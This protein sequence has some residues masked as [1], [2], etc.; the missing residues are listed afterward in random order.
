MQKRIHVLSNTHWDREWYMPL[1]KYRVRLVRMMDRL[2]DLMEREEDYLFVTD[3]QYMMVEDYLEVRPESRERV[4]ALVRAGRLLVGPWYTQ[5]LETLVTG[6]AMVRNLLMGTRRSRALGG[7]MRFAYMVDEFGHASQT[8]QVLRGFGIGDML[9]W[10]GM[11]PALPPVFTWRAP[12]GTAVTMHRSVAG[13]GE[14]TALPASMEDFTQPYEGMELARSGLASRIRRIQEIKERSA[15]DGVQFWLN[16]IDH[17]W[18][19]E[20]LMERLAQIRAHW[21]QYD[22]RPSTPGAYARDMADYLAREGVEPPAFTGELMYP[23]ELLQSTHS[24]R[25]DHKLAHYRAEHWLEKYA[26][27]MGALA[28]LTG[29][30]YPGWELERAWKLILEN[31][32]HD[33]L[34]CTSVDEVYQQCMARYGSSLSLSQQVFEDGFAHMMARL[35]REDVLCVYYP[36]SSPAGGG[37]VITL[38]IPEARGVEGFRLREPDGTPVP[39]TLLKREKVMSTRYNPTYGHPTRV[40]CRRFTVAARLPASR[41][42]GMGWLQVEPA[43]AGY[44]PRLLR[45]APYGVMENPFLRAEIQGNGTLVLT[46]KRSG[47]R[48]ERLLLLEDTGEWGN[49]YLHRRPQEDTAVTNLGAQASILRLWETELLSQYQVSYT[50]DIPEGMESDGSR[51]SGH[52]QPLSVSLLLTLFRDRPRLDVT[53]TVENRCDDHQLRL[54][55]PTGLAGAASHSGQPF[56]IVER[57]AQIPADWD[58]DGD[59]SLECH[60]MQD[61]CGAFTAEAGLAAAAKGVYE[62]A[63]TPEGTLALTLFRAVD[64]IDRF[65]EHRGTGFDTRLGQLHTTLTYELALFPHDGRLPLAEVADFVHPPV[66]WYFRSREEALL[67]GAPGL[68]PL[69]VAEGPLVE[70]GDPWVQVT[71]IKRAE[72]GEDLIL[73]LVNLADEPRETA[74]RLAPALGD[75]DAAA[76]A[77]LEETPRETAG[78]GR[79]CRVSLRPKEVC[80]LRFVRPRKGGASSAF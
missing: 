40:P 14:A 15:H 8:P 13:Y 18:A 63:L 3:G 68:A 50:L 38:D 12:D 80:T 53:L 35:G 37:A 44:A 9:A 60:P 78:R 32:A 5:P 10:R 21:P 73:R 25:A 70:T 51:R 2:L 17:S 55:L 22:V 19:Q 41:G 65:D 20:D 66:A 23:D 75:W 67:Q 39:Y 47:R 11:D 62:Y 33:S 7:V 16:G 56:D 45:E 58:L 36:N 31:H 42:L 77:D 76:R 49:F 27:P 30:A 1:E 79:E 71:M 69:P 46:D 34:G 4:Q 54:L 48:F 24:C 52:T 74:V 26:E 72:E 64:C 28:W 59:P 43:P 57:T 29:A 6:E 61:F